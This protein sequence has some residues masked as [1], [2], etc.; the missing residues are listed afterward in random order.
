MDDRARRFHQTHNW[1]QISLGGC[2][3][4]LTS[5]L[6]TSPTFAQVPHLLRYQG[7]AVDS[8]G[9][10]LDGS[11]TLILRLY[12]ASTGGNKVWEDT[13]SNV[14]ITNGYFSVLLGQG[15]ANPL[16]VDWSQPCWLGVEVDLDPL[17]N[18]ELIPRQ[19]VTSVPLALMAERLD[20]PITTVGNNVGIGTSTPNSRVV[21]Q[22][23]GATANTSSLEVT[24]A[25][26]KSLL[27]VRDSGDIRIG[28]YSGSPSGETLLD[29]YKGQLNTPQPGLHMLRFDHPGVAEYAAGLEN[30]NFLLEWVGGN[31]GMTA[32]FGAGGGGYL[33]LSINGYGNVGIG[34]INAGNILTIL[35]GSPTDPIADSWTVYSTRQSKVVLGTAPA[36]GYLAQLHTLPL[37]EW[38]RAPLVSNEEAQAALGQTNPSPQALAAMK[39][40]LA[41]AKASL[42]KF[43]TQRVGILADD[44]NLPTELLAFDANGTPI[45]IDL[46]GYVGYLHAALKEAAVRIEQLESQLPPGQTP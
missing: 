41:Q 39:Q 26:G 5:L 37:Y 32:N 18:E 43:T 42:P 9:I 14:L 44:P 25:A 11:Y 27:L 40:Q 30:G 15:P 16:N 17:V 22:G 29:L 23:T 38:T 20:G 35:Q 1:Q 12:D 2:S 45:G 4:L 28:K 33:G 19:Q 21:I 3:L 10:P 7:Q 36:Q 8:Q 34:T 13:Q 24:D 31:P 6:P 46:L